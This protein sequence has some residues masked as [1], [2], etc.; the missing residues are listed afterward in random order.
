MELSEM[1]G[2]IWIIRMDSLIH[3]AA[4]EVW[5]SFES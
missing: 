2:K 5:P 1:S 3:Y 4:H